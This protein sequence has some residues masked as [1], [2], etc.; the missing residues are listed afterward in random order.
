[1]V[2]DDN[3]GK[4]IQGS[5]TLI[6][7]KI[8][9]DVCMVKTVDI[10]AKDMKSNSFVDIVQSAVAKTSGLSEPQMVH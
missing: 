10:L 9:N 7:S 6:D 1:M 5:R 3:G 8:F 4:I 2:D